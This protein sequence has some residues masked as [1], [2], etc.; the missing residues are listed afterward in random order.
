[1]DWVKLIFYGASR[2]NPGPSGI[3]YVIRDQ[4]GAIIGKMAKPIPP[5]TNN[6]AEFAALQLGLKDCINHGLR[7]VSVEG[8]SEIAMNAIRK[9]KNPNWRLQ[10]ILE[11]ILENLNRLEHFEAKRIYREANVVADALSKISAQG[12]FIHWWV[13]SIQVSGNADQVF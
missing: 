3:G 8:D 4:S 2:G 7:N 11:K 12:S 6:I 5:D 10:V 9:K 13:Q 1:M